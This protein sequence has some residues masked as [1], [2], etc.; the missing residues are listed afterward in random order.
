MS[1]K[2]T[3][4]AAPLL[5]KAF[6]VLEDI[7]GSPAG[8]G[9]SELARRLSI[10]KSTVWGITQALTALGALT[11]HER[12]RKFVLGPTLVRLGN[13][14]LAGTDIRSL[15][16]PYLQELRREFDETV[17]MGTFGG[18]WITIVE[19]AGGA[20]ELRLDAPVG[21]R[22]PLFAGAAAKVFLAGQRDEDLERILR[23]NPL[24][25]Y[26]E[27]SI[28]DAAAY[29]RELARVRQKGYATDFGEY[30]PG[31]NAVS[32]PLPDHTGRPAAALW[33]V[34]FNHTFTKE[35]MERAVA[36]SLRIA[37]AIG[38]LPGRILS[39]TRG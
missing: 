9:V 4:Y 5:H 39:S 13:Q 14:A 22:I 26:T 19:R 16:R 1:E 15:V 33:M 36:A 18:D 7:A 24:P 10:S 37:A 20:Q 11:Y 25:R 30:M 29:R 2:N 6:A 28:C 31:V 3:G 17:F 35:K 12:T 27:N 21:T 8:L 32:V 34:G 23:E 38:P